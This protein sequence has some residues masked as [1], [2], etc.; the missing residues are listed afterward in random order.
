MILLSKLIK[1]FNNIPLVK[2]L[3]YID[4]F[5]PTDKKITKYI[6]PYKK[7]YAFHW[8]TILSKNRTHRY[9]TKMDIAEDL[10]VSPRTA[11]RYLSSKDKYSKIH[12]RSSDITKLWHVKD[13]VEKHCVSAYFRNG[14]W[15]YK[16]NY[17][18]CGAKN[19]PLSVVDAVTY[20]DFIEDKMIPKPKFIQT[21]NREY[22]DIS[23]YTKNDLIKKLINRSKRL[24]IAHDMINS[25]KKAE[26]KSERTIND[27]FY[28]YHAI[29][30][31]KELERRYSLTKGT[32]KIFMKHHMMKS[33]LEIKLKLWNAKEEINLIPPYIKKLKSSNLF[34]NDPDK[35]ST[36]AKLTNRHHCFSNYK[37]SKTGSKYVDNLIKKRKN[38]PTFLEKIEKKDLH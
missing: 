27:L 4:G 37:I 8:G 34:L 3:G 21:M 36:E 10:S 23:K 33:Y 38:N 7:N 22:N 19:K 17:I 13:D 24:L 30:H 32:P 16:N 2:K 20:K 26:R 25:Y 1:R 29:N 35:Y 9:F 28:A 15:F 12:I 6:R 5:S 11:N 14:K 18:T 31:Y